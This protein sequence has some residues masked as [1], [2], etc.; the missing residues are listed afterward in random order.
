[1]PQLPNLNF[2][3]IK[4]NTWKITVVIKFLKLGETMVFGELIGDNAHFMPLLLH[5]QCRIK[6]KPF[7]AT[8]PKVG[9][10]E[11]NF[12]FRLVN[13]LIKFQILEKLFLNPELI[14]CRI[15]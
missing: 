3:H 1:M 5:C 7:S 12:H 13:Y 11:D 6:Y 4:V 9:V 8:N 2:C 14:V 15:K 10:K